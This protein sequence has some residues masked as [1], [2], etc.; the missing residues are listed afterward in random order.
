MSEQRFRTVLRGYDP[1][2]VDAVLVKMQES[3]AQSSQDAGEATVAMTKLQ[4]QV[5]SLQQHLET[6]HS[7]LRSC[8]RKRTRSPRSRRSRISASGSARC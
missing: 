5:Q 2:E 4:A 3:L 7:R 8:R 1:A 6:A